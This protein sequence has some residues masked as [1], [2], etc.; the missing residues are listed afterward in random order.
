MFSYKF[1]GLRGGDCQNGGCLDCDIGDGPVSR[2]E[3][4][5]VLMQPGHIPIIITHMEAVCSTKLL[6]STYKNM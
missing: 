2:V 5:K 1:L 4:M 3:V 6:V